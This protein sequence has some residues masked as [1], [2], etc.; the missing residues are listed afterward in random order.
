MS[1]LEFITFLNYSQAFVFIFEQF[2]QIKPNLLSIVIPPT[3]WRNLH[4]E[5]NL[6]LHQEVIEIQLTHLLLETE[7]NQTPL[8]F[9]RQIQSPSSSQTFVYN[10]MM[11]KFA[12]IQDSSLEFLI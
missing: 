12:N 3:F 4:R 10:R 5:G 2:N 7:K 11:R 6:F 1:N 9:G 8:C